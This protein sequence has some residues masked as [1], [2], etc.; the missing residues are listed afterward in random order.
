MKSLKKSLCLLIAFV[1][2]IPATACGKKPNGPENPEATLMMK[3]PDLGYGYEWLKALADRYTEKTG[4]PTWVEVT[5]VDAAYATEIQGGASKYD[6]Y[7]NRGSA[8]TLVAN[9][10]R[11]GARTYECILED[12]TDI[13]TSA[14]PYDDNRT[15]IKDKL[16]DGYEYYNQVL[17]DS[18]G[19]GTP[20]VHY[21]GV[22][23]VD[24]IVGIVRNK[25]V[26]KDSW[27]TPNTTD[28]LS[29]LCATIKSQ[30]YTPFIW[31]QSSNYWMNYW[32]VW[33]YQYQGYNDMLRFWE[34]LPEKGRG[35][36]PSAAMWDRKGWKEAMT[37]MENL[38]AEENGYMHK[39]S[40]TSDFTTAQGYF[41]GND[42]IAMMINGD[43][44]E[45]EMKKN[46][47]N[48]RLDVIK[49]PV[50]SAIINVL[51]DKSVENDAEL[52]ALIAAIDEGKTELS[53]VGYEVTQADY[54]RVK[55]ARDT[56]INPLTNHQAYIPVYSEKKSIAKDFLQFMASD[57]G[58]TV[59]SESSKGF[60]LP[61]NYSTEQTESI[62]AVAGDYVKSC[63]EA[64][65]GCS[66][67]SS[68]MYRSRLF[69]VGGMP[70]TP[71]Y[72]LGNSVEVILSAKK[73]TDTY[74]N[75]A[76]IYRLNLA[77][78]Q[79]AAAAFSQATGITF[80]R[81]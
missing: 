19:D 55:T 71:C 3:I 39:Y 67:V 61:Y 11:V 70:F 24:S 34:G 63:I 45:N 75:A 13:Y 36:T 40:M 47:P 81:N 69:T 1:A 59:M 5:D 42:N 12:L 28:E 43:W 68:A 20:E 22:Q 10:V 78:V 44:I 29:G 32:P 65:N 79:S 41:L 72:Q 31:S 25:S 74:R 37:V 7:F 53:G 52:S 49:T 4:T 56:Y 23:Y 73:S 80:K 38:L 54:D 27:K 35:D 26:W 15:T 62:K 60:L 51:P 17:K 33:V 30:G 48:T 9:P 66:M 76:E 46:Y 58:M 6:L 21:Y 14:N 16:R 2:L 57:E 77:N 8:H 18:D 64:R 50:I